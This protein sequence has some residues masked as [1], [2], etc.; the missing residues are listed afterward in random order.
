MEC[1]RKGLTGL[2]VGGED[3]G[4]DS[5]A[6]SSSKHLSDLKLTEHVLKK[7][8]VRVLPHPVES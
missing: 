4:S 2:R 5:E 3:K 6:E 8:I 1:Y 7:R